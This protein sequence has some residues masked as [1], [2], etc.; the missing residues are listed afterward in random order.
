MIVCVGIGPGDLSFL[1]Q[2]AVD[3]FQTADVV[4]GFD[5]VLNVVAPLIDPKATVVPLS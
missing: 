5:S 1:T 4:S 2:R 3:L